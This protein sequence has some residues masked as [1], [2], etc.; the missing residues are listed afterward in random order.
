MIAWEQGEWH[1]CLIDGACYLGWADHWQTMITGVLAVGAAGIAA[2]LARGQLDAAR[3]QGRLAR[4]QVTAQRFE[5]D[6]RR[7]R[8][9]R[10]AR[11]S[12]PGVLTAICNHAE[13]V[14]RALHGLWPIDAIDH[15]Y[16]NPMAHVYDVAGDVP[17]FPTEL[18]QPLQEIIH[19]AN[20]EEV[21]QRIASIFR[22]AQVLDARVRPLNSGARIT[23]REL[24]QYMLE[25]AA[26][27][28]RAES[29]FS[30]ARGQSETIDQ[31]D[32]WIRVLAALNICGIDLEGVNALAAEE[33]ELGLPPGEAD[34]QPIR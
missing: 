20:N 31:S 17:V 9:L 30:F 33:R 6:D 25:A 21:I 12:L 7:R 11:A 32:L 1:W 14:T 34:T 19:H 22:E 5:D 3:E 4:E 27:Y 29:L 28:A 26:L 23:I 13:E 2:Y 18:I 10:A 15:P 24:E 8:A 16:A